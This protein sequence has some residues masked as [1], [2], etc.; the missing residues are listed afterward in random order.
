MDFSFS[1]KKN[2]TGTTGP[3]APG[4][5][6]GQDQYE[7]LRGC[8]IVLTKPHG[9]YD[10]SRGKRDETFAK[11]PYAALLLLMA[12]EKEYGEFWA[13]SVVLVPACEAPGETELTD[14]YNHL[15]RLVGDEVP[16]GDGS[17]STNYETNGLTFTAEVNSNS[18]T[19]DLE[20][21]DLMTQMLTKVGGL[22]AAA[23]PMRLARHTLPEGSLLVY[24]T[25]SDLRD[26]ADTTK[27][28][29]TVLE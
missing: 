29:W 12:S 15:K 22:L 6:H 21:G 3:Q 5:S 2:T 24:M 23:G 26:L 1:Y 7:K 25:P 11:R 10:I 9:W 17:A 18:E 20:P 8:G 28:E 14:A 4:V 16:M 19:W 13:S 27:L